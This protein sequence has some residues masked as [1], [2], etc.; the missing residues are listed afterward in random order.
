MGQYLLY[1]NTGC[2]G[3]MYECA[4]K[5]IDY[6]KYSFVSGHCIDGF[7]RR[8]YRHQLVFKIYCKWYCKPV[9][10]V[11]AI[12]FRL[13]SLMYYFRKRFTIETL[14]GSLLILVG[15]VFYIMVQKKVRSAGGE[16]FIW[17][18]LMNKTLQTEHGKIEIYSAKEKIWKTCGWR[19]IKAALSYP[20]R[21][22][23]K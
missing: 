15:I 1:G 8:A 14:V 3:I 21:N 13:S 11:S 5:T 16:G 20:A 4:I 10:A 18:M 9:D 22:Q 2:C 17:K 6:F 19:S 23:S 12:F 7:M